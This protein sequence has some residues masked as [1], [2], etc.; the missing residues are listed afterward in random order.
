MPAPDGG[1]I[2]CVVLVLPLAC[3]WTVEPRGR[4]AS[5]PARPATESLFA[6]GS[7]L[8]RLWQIIL[9]FHAFFCGLRNGLFVEHSHCAR[10][11]A[12]PATTPL[13][14]LGGALLRTS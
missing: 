12:A 4:R 5:A 14:A 10:A 7:A 9:F 6:N 1:A 8:P 13:R 2:C 3:A 11:V